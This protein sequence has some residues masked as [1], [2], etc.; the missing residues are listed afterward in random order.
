M[1]PIPDPEAPSVRDLFTVDGR[2][3]PC[4]LDEDLNSTTDG[5]L[6]AA[7][8]YPAYYS[9][10]RHLTHSATKPRLLEIGVR[11]GYIPVVFAKASLGRSY[12]MGVDPNLYVQHGL[13]LASQSLQQ[14]RSC[15]AT[16]DFA[17]IQGYS[18]DE[19]VRKSI[20]YSGP[21]DLIHID[22]DHT[23]EGKLVDL[24]LARSVLADKGI[25][26]VDDY[27]HH[28]CVRDA[29]ERAIRIGLFRQFAYLPTFRGLALLRP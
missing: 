17:I 3:L 9:L 22:G 14:I 13:T 1:I 20:L 5:W 8:N 21:F 26:L 7:N 2:E 4:W 10:F 29:I 24:D 28:L 25:V 11:T 16:F 19:W 23:L 12:Y 18:W 27:D 6:T 15:F